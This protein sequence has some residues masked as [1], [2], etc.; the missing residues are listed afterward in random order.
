MGSL[1]IE[2]SPRPEEAAYG[3]LLRA[4]VANGAS[5]RELLALT[6]GSTRR[7]LAPA[8]VHLFSTLTTVDEH[9]FATRIPCEVRGDRWVEIEV[10][11]TRWRND[12][13]LRG[14]HCQVCPSCLL[15]HRFVRFEW[16]LTA[17]VACHIHGQLL[18]DRCSEC[19][20]ALLPNR[21]AIDVCSCG[22]F[23]AARDAINADA[24]IIE[25]CRWLSAT[26]LAS[27]GLS[28]EPAP[29]PLNDLAGMSADGAFRMIV[30]L[31]GGSRELRGAHMNSASPWLGTTGVYA[32][33]TSGF[34]ALQDLHAGRKPAVPLGLGCGD[35]LSEQSVRG[36][37]SFDRHAAAAMLAKLKLRSRWRN[38]RPVVHT[39]GDLFEGWA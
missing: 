8:D 9:W 29:M 39:Q 36:I 26:L 28:A 13:T 23:I 38:V 18:V 25:W 10:F 11:N 27:M 15:E 6:R 37:T 22:R 2:V 30:A 17:C 24:V 33:L 20:R 4:L 12:W 19:G 34:A 31:G 14:Q 1:P 16:D 21:P 35:A 3:F 7:Q 5:A 32:V